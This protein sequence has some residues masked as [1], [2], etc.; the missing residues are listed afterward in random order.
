LEAIAKI[1]EE[2]QKR[3]HVMEILSYLTD[4]YGPRLTGSPNVKQ[5]QEW[6]EGQLKNWGLQN[7]HVEPWGPFGRGWTLAGFSANVVAPQF[8]PMIAYPK[9]W[10]P[11][12]DGPIKAQPV[13]LDAKTVADL[14]KYK[15]KL[16]GAI[17]L[18]DPARDVKADFEPLGERLNADKLLELADAPEPGGRG[19]FRR[20]QPTAEMKARAELQAKKWQMCYDEGA[21]VILE[22]GRGDGGTIFVQQVNIPAPPDTP[23]DQRPRP[24]ASTPPKI[25]PQVAVAVEHYNRLIRMIEKGATPTLEVEI[26]S[27]FYDSDPMS[28]NLVAEIPGTDLKDQIVM[29]GGHFDSWQAGT[30]ATDNG[31]GSAVALEAVRIIQ[32]LGLKPRRTIRIALWTGEEEGLLGSRAYVEQHFG[33][34]ILAPGQSIFS[35][36]ASSTPPKFEL[37]PDQAKVSGYF[38]LDNGTGKIRGVYLQGNEAIAS[39]FREWLAP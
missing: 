18:L 19:G 17:V 3:S 36:D 5:A 34:R 24:W 38:N 37:K 1:K 25:V 9:A 20:P 16:K 23:F 32:S 39:L 35:A 12:T 13:Y 14:D 29:L 31:A 27:N 21:G 7:V 30:G 6:V 2:G 33:K 10:S 8:L 26:K 15:G 4:V 22:P 11:S 28:Y